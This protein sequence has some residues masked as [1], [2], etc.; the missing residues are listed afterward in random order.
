MPEL[1]AQLGWELKI[2]G[3]VDLDTASE[4]WKEPDIC[5]VFFTENGTILFISIDKC[6]EAYP[7]ENVN[8]LAF[9][10]SEVS[11]SFNLN[12]CENGIEKRSFMA[13]ENEIVMEDGEPLDAEAD[14]DL[15]EV[16]WEQ[17]KVVLGKRFMDID[18]GE[19]AIRYRFVE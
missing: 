11:M 15:S 7:L 6:M 13:T 3:E 10:M 1:Q 12:Y 8:T 16:I 9:V 5:D 18:L 17:I 4:N 2:E 14:D 19:T